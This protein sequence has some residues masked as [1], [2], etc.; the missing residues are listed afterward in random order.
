MP[1]Y[2]QGE[3]L[4]QAV[5]SVLLQDY[6]NLEFIVMDGGSTDESTAILSKYDAHFS[7]WQSQKDEGQA[8]AIASG[9]ERS[10]GEILCWLNSDDILLPGA[11]TH[12]AG[13]FAAR[14][15]VDFVYGNRIVIDRQGRMTGRHIWPYFLSR[16]HWALGQP[17]A[18]ECCFWR[19]A[20]YEQVGGL[21][22]DKFF[23]MDYDLFFRMWRVCR[24]RKTRSYLGALRVHEE[25]KN[26][27]HADIWRSELARAKTEFQLRDPGYFRLRFMN[28]AD[29][30]QRHLER[31]ADG[32]SRA[33]I[34]GVIP[35][36]DEPL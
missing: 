19:R 3:F 31:L 5:R 7:Y 8:D 16:Y 32:L 22:R 4:E 21:N 15:R 17:M 11:L 6:E 2:N 27:R 12:V 30:A 33:R 34:P 29:L 18:Q 36:A 35:N 10:T 23:I 28:R 14:R 25:T 26:S 13:I 1:S 9:F 20:A 24:F